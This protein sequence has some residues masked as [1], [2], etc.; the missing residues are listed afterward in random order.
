M[1]KVALKS[2]NKTTYQNGFTLI[3]V[4]LVFVLIGLFVSAIRFNPFSH[5]PEIELEEAS[6]RFAGIFNIAAEY[7]L[8]NNI[9]LGLITDK[10]SY[11]FVGFDGVEW[12]EITEQPAFELYEL[13]EHIELTLELEYLPTEEPNLLDDV[14]LFAEENQ[15]D[16]RNQPEEK[17]LLP[18][19]YLL[20]GGDITPFKLIFAFRDEFDVEQNVEFHI[21]GSYTLPLTIK[22]PIFDGET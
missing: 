9:E 12:S 4:M 18:K 3:E 1:K 5:S 15:D 17:K 14:E 19:V 2:K 7:G 11:Q 21:L 16:F 10:N 13:P 20:S 22:G 6:A 8:L